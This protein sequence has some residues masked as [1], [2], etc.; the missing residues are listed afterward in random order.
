VEDKEIRSILEH[1]L[2][3]SQAHVRKLTSFFI[4]EQ[5]P[6]P[7]GFSEEK[8]CIKQAPRLYTDDFY[9]FYIQ[10]IGKAGLQHY[11]M[12]IGNC[13]RLD[14]C[15]YFTECLNESTRLLNISTETMLNKGTFIRSPYIPKPHSVEYVQKQS[16]MHE[17][18]GNHRPLNVIEISNLYFNLIQNQLGRSLLMGFSQVASSD[19]VRD[20]MVRGRNI[21]DKHVEIFGS[22][23]G[24][25]YLPSASAWDTLPTDST[26][27]PFSDKLIMYHV[28][29]LNAA[30]I[31]HYGAGLAQSPRS[32]L[33]AAYVRLISEITQFCNDG[34]NIM[35]ENNWLEQPPQTVDRDQLAKR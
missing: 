26:V 7:D 3:L 27:S 34:A 20:F 11:T 25:E 1:S 24:D 17:W 32:D 23:L 29:T 6:V 14:L 5:L 19:T 2:Q 4:E 18:F 15:E 12:A 22:L 31:I 21:A 8:D 30:G 9:L 35:I 28:M 10:N 33:A 16:Y 13:A